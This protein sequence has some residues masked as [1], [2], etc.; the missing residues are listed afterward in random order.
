MLTTYKTP[1]DALLLA[2]LYPR[3][4]AERHRAAI[5][6]GKEKSGTKTQRR[7]TMKEKTNTE[8]TPKKQPPTQRSC[9]PRLMPNNV[10]TDANDRTRHAPQKPH[11]TTLKINIICVIICMYGTSV[12]IVTCVTREITVIRDLTKKGRT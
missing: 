2:L 4:A 11:K 7:K 9:C 10:L 1:P 5:G 3:H 8:R 12:L 6:T